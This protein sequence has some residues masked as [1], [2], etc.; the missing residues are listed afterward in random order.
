V[1]Q[2]PQ[3]GVRSRRFSEGVL[4]AGERRQTAVSDEQVAKAY[5]DAFPN[6][7][8]IEAVADRFDWSRQHAKN[9]ISRARKAGLLPETRPGV[10]RA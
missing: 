7:E 9:R 10:P 2:R 4:D 6:E 3:D 8:V 5:K 1:P